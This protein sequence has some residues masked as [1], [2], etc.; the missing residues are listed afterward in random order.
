ML[1]SVFAFAQQNIKLFSGSIY[2]DFGVDFVQ[3]PSLANLG[4]S[5]PF[6][7]QGSLSFTILPLVLYSFAYCLLITNGMC[8]KILYL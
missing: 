2:T 1:F 6:L 7:Y 4:G 8:L 3:D 5:D